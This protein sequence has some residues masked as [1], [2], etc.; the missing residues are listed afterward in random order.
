MNMQ[1]TGSRPPPEMVLPR[2]LLHWAETRGSAI[3]LRQ[4]EYGIWQAHDWAEYARMARHF[5]L[6][7]VAL[8]LTPGEHVAMLSESRR[9]WVVA[10]LGTNLVGGVAVGIYPTE[11]ANEVDYLLTKADVTILV[12]EDQE[13]FDKALAIRS[14]LA[15]LRSIVVMDP[16]GIEINEGD[17][18]SFEAVLA[19]GAREEERQ[20]DL[21]ERRV[22]RLTPEDPALMV[23]TSGSTGRPKAAVLTYRNINASG[24]AVAAAYGIHEGDSVVSYLPLC[25]VAEQIFTVHLPL[26]VGYTVNFAES[27]RTVQSDM[28]EIGP[29]LFLGVP[30]IWEKMHASISIKIMETGPLPRRIFQAALAVLRPLANRPRGQWSLIDRLHYGVWYWLVLRALL[31]FIGLRRGRYC[32]S[33]AAPIGPELL[34]FF[35]TLG[36]PIRELYGMTETCGVA[37]AQ[38]SDASPVGTVGVPIAGM[39]V[40]L[41]ED[42]ELLMRGAQIFSHYYQDDAATHAAKADG[43]LHSGDI[44]ERAGDEFRIIDRKKDI[45]ITAGGKNI[46]PSEVE[47]ALKSSPYIKEAIAIGDR[48]SF[49]SALIQIDAETVSKWAE[50]KGITYTTFRSLAEHKVVHDLIAA[51]VARANATMPQVQQVRRF[52][53]LTKELDHDDGEVTATMKVRRSAIAKMF[54]DEIEGLYDKAERQIA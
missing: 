5:G 25:H 45:L 2:R 49:V 12:C 36:V 20:P 31:N 13:Q 37:L 32:F 30:R 27:L 35:R 19:L 17:V 26:S 3:A 52:H 48:R 42:G 8:G 34:T 18:H 9:E 22:G 40:A 7:L 21:I 38:I 4:K 14:N 47:N 33:G 16:E 29:T 6:G 51:E 28:R 46:S 23:F 11:S 54:A 39:E 10:Q 41:A 15:K 1:L 50:T 24:D 43:W 53:L 44:A